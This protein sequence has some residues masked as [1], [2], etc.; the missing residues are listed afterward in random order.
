MQ[1][2]NPLDL[3]VS[4]AN[5]DGKESEIDGKGLGNDGKETKI[6]GKGLENDGKENW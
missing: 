5:Y 4:G 1:G 6:D 2:D 3:I